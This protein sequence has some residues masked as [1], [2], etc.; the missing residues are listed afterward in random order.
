M[1]HAIVLHSVV[2][3]RLNPDEGAEQLTQLLFAE[4]CDILDEKPRWIRVK[5]HL[6]GQEGWVDFKMI[7]DMSEEE[8]L[9]NYSEIKENTYKIH[10]ILCEIYTQN[11]IRHL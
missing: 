6:D 1:K 8:Y 11:M 5:S 7:T 9:N 4:T 10:I 2:P 3:V